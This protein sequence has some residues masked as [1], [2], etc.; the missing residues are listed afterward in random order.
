MKAGFTLEIWPERSSAHQFIP[1]QIC[2]IRWRAYNMR[3][4]SGKMAEKHHGTI[5]DQ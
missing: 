4:F 2:K 1:L 3:R 5:K